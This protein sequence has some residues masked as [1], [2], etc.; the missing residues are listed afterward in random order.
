M[1][2]PLEFDEQ[3]SFVEYLEAK[4]IKFSSTAQSTWTSSWKQKTKNKQS[5]LRR[6][7][8]D[9]VLILWIDGSKHLVFIEMK[10]AKKSLSTVSKEQKEWIKE[11]NECKNV[12]AYVCYGA[13]E[14]I[15]LV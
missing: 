13:K 7:L 15:D 10:R 12:G 3:V 6:G 9:L 5:G 2:V 1:T 8:P 11:L 4:G 14:A